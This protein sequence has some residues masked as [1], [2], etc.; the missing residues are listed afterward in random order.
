MGWEAGLPFPHRGLALAAQTTPPPTHPGLAPRGVRG[1]R[2]REAG[3]GPEVTQ[4]QDP[5]IVPDK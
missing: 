5:L 2:E 4:R 1:P 3:A